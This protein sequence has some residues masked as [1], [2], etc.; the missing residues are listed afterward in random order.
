MHSR[1]D[2]PSGRLPL[3]QTLCAF[4]DRYGSPYDRFTKN[5][6]TEFD[7]PMAL[8]RL[9]SASHPGEPSFDSFAL[10]RADGAFVV[11][12]ALADDRFAQDPIVAGPP[13]IRFFASC[14]VRTGDGA[15]LGTLSILD[16]KPRRFLREQRIRL[17]EMAGRLASELERIESSA[18]DESTGL[19]NRTGFQAYATKWRERARKAQQPLSWL[20][21]TIDGPLTD[22]FADDVANVLRGA[23]RAEDVLGRLKSAEFAVLLPSA[24]AEAR[25]LASHRIHQGLSQYEV[26]FR[27]DATTVDP[28]APVAPITPSGA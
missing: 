14:A 15:V 12:D 22:Q 26:R 17:E 28:A 8:V 2:D 24:A 1:A 10:R 4:D 5:A 13:N 18:V 19:L 6:R 25:E 7:V 27:I 9:V 16:R 20:F 21:V 3:L 23:A 11:E